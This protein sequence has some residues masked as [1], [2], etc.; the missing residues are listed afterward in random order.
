VF[1]KSEGGSVYKSNNAGASWIN[2]TP[3]LLGTSDSGVGASSADSKNVLQIIYQEKSQ[4]MI[5]QGHVRDNW[6]T[7]DMVGGCTRV[8]SS[9]VP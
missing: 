9:C 2:E 5:L 6:A 8:E 4:F 1:A 3:I 7:K